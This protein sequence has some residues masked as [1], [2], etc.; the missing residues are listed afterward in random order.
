VVPPFFWSNQ[1]DLHI[2]YVGHRSGENRASVSGNLKARDASVIFRSGDKL[3]ALASI[4]SDLEISKPKWRSSA[5]MSF[6]DCD[7][8]AIGRCRT[9]WAN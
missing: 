8:I 1:F 9:N 7:F 5:A 2:R 6:T 4:D 3:N